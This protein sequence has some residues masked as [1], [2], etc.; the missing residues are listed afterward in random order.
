MIT[1]EA[2]HTTLK[3][4]NRFGAGLEKVKALAGLCA[5]HHKCGSTRVAHGTLFS[6]QCLSC[7]LVEIWFVQS[8]ACDT[9]LVLT[10]NISYI[11]Y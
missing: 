9:D 2:S 8:I 5:Y 10:D 1:V 4:D 6:C 11:L 7:C 3:P